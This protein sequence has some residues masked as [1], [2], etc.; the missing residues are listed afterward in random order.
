MDVASL[1][2]I[3]W[4]CK[5]LIGISKFTLCYSGNKDRQGIRGVRFIVS[6]KAGKSVLGFS[7][8]CE[9]ICILRIKGKIHNIIFVNVYAPTDDTEDEIVDE[10]YETL[11]S[12]CDEL[13]KRDAIITIGNFNAKLGKEQIYKDI[14]GRQ[15]T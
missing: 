8:I 11:Q 10:F 14:I 13:P 4:K 6:K 15:P 2:E 5:S 1:Q 12:V 9:R 3:R 7:P